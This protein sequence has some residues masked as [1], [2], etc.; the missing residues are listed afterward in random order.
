VNQVHVRGGGFG[1][2]AC[3]GVGGA[4]GASSEDGGAFLSGDGDGTTRGRMDPAR[5]DR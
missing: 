4:G 5:T 1:E 2:G 3:G